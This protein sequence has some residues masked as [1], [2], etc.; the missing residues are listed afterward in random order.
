MNAL[1]LSCSVIAVIVLAACGGSDNERPEPAYPPVVGIT[2]P[3]AIATTTSDSVTVHAIALGLSNPLTTVAASLN[4]V[5]V[6]PP[7]LPNAKNRYQFN[8]TGMTAGS[9]NTIKVTASD[10]NIS[11]S[12]THGV[13]YGASWMV[14]RGVQ[15]DE[16]NERA[17]V[18]D[19]AKK[20]VLAINLTT[21][22]KTE[23]SGYNSGSGNS[24][25]APEDMVIDSVGDA[26]VVD[27]GLQ[28]I[29]GINLISGEQLADFDGTNS[30]P[31]SS[32]AL[33]N[34]VALTLAV[35]DCIEYDIENKSC[36][37]SD[38]TE[39]PALFTK[40]T[41]ENARQECEFL[42]NEDP[43]C[44]FYS[45]KSIANGP[46]DNTMECRGCRLGD[47]DL[48]VS[49]RAD[50][51][52]F[53]RG[54]NTDQT[55]V[56]D[57]GQQKV[58]PV[59]LYSYETP[60]QSYPAR[61]HFNPPVIY[62]QPGDSE[63][64]TITL[65]EPIINADQNGN[66]NLSVWLRSTDPRVSYTPNNI[67]WE[68]N[69]WSQSKTFMASMTGAA[70][71]QHLSPQIAHVRTKSELY[72]DF[73]PRFNVV[74][75]QPCSLGSLS[76]PA[77]L[78]FDTQKD[79]DISNDR[80][81]IVEKS[82][83]TLWQMKVND[84]SLTVLS[85]ATTPDKQ[86]PF[87]AIQDITLSADNTKAYISDAGRVAIVEVDLTDGGRTLLVD[88]DE[89][90]G[91]D[92]VIRPA[93]TDNSF[94]S[95]SALTIGPNNQL[96]VVDN[97]LGV[98]AK[99][100]TKDSSGDL[101][102]KG[103]RDYV[104]AGATTPAEG[105]TAA[106]LTALA[107]DHL[108]GRLSGLASNANQ[109]VLYTIDR[110]LGEV[111]QLAPAL[112]A[113]VPMY[114]L[115]SNTIL[116]SNGELRFSDSGLLAA[117]SSV[118]TSEEDGTYADINST[119]GSGSD[120]VFELTVDDGEVTAIQVTTAGEAYAYGDTLTLGSNGDSDFSSL[121]LTLV[122]DVVQLTDPRTIASRFGV[123]L[124]PSGQLYAQ[125]DWLLISISASSLSNLTEG[126]FSNIVAQSNMNGAG[127]EFSITVNSEQKITAIEVDAV[128]SGYINGER[129]T[130]AGEDFGASG[131][132]NLILQEVLQDIYIVDAASEDGQGSVIQI[133][134]TGVNEGNRTLLPSPSSSDT[135]FIDPVT[136]LVLGETL[137]VLDSSG[138][139]ITV[140]LN[141]DSLGNRSLLATIPDAR[142]MVLDE[143]GD[144]F[145]VATNE[146]IKKVNIADGSVSPHLSLVNAVD[147]ADLLL[148]TGELFD[149]N[150]DL[151][152]NDDRLL[153]LDAGLGKVFG[154]ADTSS[155][156]LI[157]ETPITGPTIPNSANSFITPTKMAYDSN[158]QWL[159]VLDET[160]RSLFVVDL[161]ARDYDDGGAQVDAQTVVIIQGTALNQ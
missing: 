78:V 48:D 47:N 89:V 107:A 137:Y 131:S 152:A 105:D 143:T 135:A 68:P 8:V 92:T 108:M 122:N 98:M 51:Y 2:F 129:L 104:A 113:V 15:Y 159:Y 74:A 110:D 63:E 109:S 16:I 64:V 112:N 55:F 140:S 41:V 91:D 139:M 13:T 20:A 72:Q 88:G 61:I 42:C 43:D 21:G 66:Q 157:S 114:D 53:C 153:L 138:G 36:P 31:S 14:E 71:P 30:D 4:D 125:S 150:G 67:E 26:W 116:G 130:I 161:Q 17:L 95:P 65:E 155:L 86:N 119:G 59:S 117:L 85:D 93:N 101:A 39:N 97:S 29:I 147:I 40:T 46:E 145:Y 23:V 102:Y 80:L 73:S 19:A 34:P 132:F 54:V 96:L 9:Q 148:D 136:A 158:H 123:K 62:L 1:K 11:Q 58:V 100:A 77:N 25:V 44:S 144:S 37:S 7:A 94:A 56:L 106:T 156:D 18:V 99:V 52:S 12:T 142:A 70:S 118:N 57:P 28:K 134:A 120:A 60:V 87:I 160:L 24:L 83:N 90:D 76:D 154:I 128:G 84:C 49:D 115:T 32:S 6:D 5:A 45:L 50:T 149:Q 3:P 22:E 82:K 33:N 121:S 79:N 35:N 10:A 124:G 111:K 126:V 151:D 75:G 146:A 127:A 69:E 133:T 81:L 27:S 141:E 103:Q 38:D